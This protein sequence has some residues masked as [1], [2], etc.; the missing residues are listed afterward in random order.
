MAIL[1]LFRRNRRDAQE[2][3]PEENSNITTVPWAARGD[4][5]VD[6]VS[7]K[8][9]ALR[10]ATVYRCADIL[11]KGV[12]Q[13][14][15]EITRNRG[16][17]FASDNEDIFNLSYLL[18]WRPNERMSAFEMMRSTILAMLFQ[19]NAYLVP[20][21]GPDGYHRLVLCAP[22]TVTYEKITNSYVISDVTNGVYGTYPAAEVIHLKNLGTDG[23]YTGVSTIE[24]G[25]K[26]LAISSNGD[27][28]HVD[29]F[30]SGGMV[31]GFVSGKGGATVGFGAVQDTQL[32]SVAKNI[33]DQLNSGK[34][35]FNLPG[36]MSFNQISLSPK[37]IEL[38]ATKEFN[39]LEICRFFGVHP[40]K[41]FAGQSTNYKASENSQVSFLTDTLQPYLTQIVA[42]FTIKLIPR[43][44]IDTY[45]ISFDLSPLM[46]TDLL[47][48]ADYLT[49]MIAI[50][51]LTINEARRSMGQSP[52][53][54]G[55][56][57]LVSAN[58]LALN[59]AKLRGEE[60]T[61][62]K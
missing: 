13:L 62:N 30:K 41:V 56:D 23:G 16:G 54:G 12:A 10:I 18:R 45:R 58:L 22:N 1:D 29:T 37:D 38:L 52:V 39:V 17:Y 19:G 3:A 11:S 35:I 21:M 32:A 53:E 42:E 2:A 25:A 55:D 47:S 7:T 20:E 44:L 31:R 36:E 27:L 8:E 60:A 14:P 28:R 57:P 51:A 43:S 26:V 24:Y 6:S 4:A 34:A 61:Q 15:L 59:S 50:G 5:G 49:K 40:D 46:Q 33:E 48:K 9:L